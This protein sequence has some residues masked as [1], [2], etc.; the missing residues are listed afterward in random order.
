MRVR[1]GA[2]DRAVGAL[3]AAGVQLAF[4]GRGPLAWSGAQSGESVFALN[5][6]S[7]NIEEL[8]LP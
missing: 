6:E 8:V 7:L 4:L 2:Q 1:K 5:C 3:H